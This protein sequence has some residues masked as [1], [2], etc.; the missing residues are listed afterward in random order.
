VDITNYVLLECG[1]PLHAFDHA[2]LTDGQIVVRRVRPGEKMATL[3][4]IERELTPEMLVIADAAR[5][6]AVAGVMGGAGS[7]IGE[8]TT[9]VLLESACFDPTSIHRTSVALG[10][11]TE[12]SHR[13]ERGVDIEAVDWAGRRA[14]RL[15]VEHAGAVA[16]RG[17]VDAFPAP[18]KAP[19]VLCRFARARSLLGMAIP[20]GEIT[21]ILESLGLPVTDRDE[22]SCTVTVPPF[23]HDLHIEADLIEEIARMH[24][25]DRVCPALPAAR[26]DPDADDRRTRAV[27]ACRSRMAA[28]GLTE[29]MHYSFVAGELLDRFECGPKERRLVLPNPVSSEHAVMRDAL[30]PQMVET[31]GRNLSRQ[32]D[33]AAFFE[34]GRVY[35]AGGDGGHVEEQRLAVGLMGQAGRVA[36]PGR[37]APGEEDVFLWLK[38]ILQQLLAAQHVENVQIVPGGPSCMAPGWGFTLRAGDT[39]I[40]V[41]GLLNRSVAHAWRLEDAVGIA[42]VAIDPLLADAFAIPPLRPVPAYPGI[43]R[44]LAVIVDESVRHEDIVK[45]IRKV[46]PGELTSIELFDIFRGKGVGEACKSLAYSLNYRS[47]E[48]TMTDEDA[49]AYHAGIMKAL[50]S[51]LNAKIRDG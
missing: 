7:E 5:P 14:A 28:L 33:S 38:G 18:Y 6:V 26:I 9:A 31:L 16:A 40:G 17:V 10:L 41:L 39:N 2:L 30:I 48:R 22:E 50:E 35:A 45:T 27:S 25:L 15:M 43:T 37:K 49:N 24:G 1:Q 42:E 32:V 36:Q 20:D 13:F 44:D 4:E 12:S 3:D 34:I 19:R 47:L 21:G 46:G 23:R 29:V 8:N 51:E 11:A